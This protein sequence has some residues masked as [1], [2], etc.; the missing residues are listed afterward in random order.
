MFIE[1]TSTKVTFLVYVSILG[2]YKMDSNRQK[3]HINENI[4]KQIKSIHSSNIIKITRGKW[5]VTLQED[6]P[7][8]LLSEVY[9]QTN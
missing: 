9:F 6:I 4:R 7:D 3:T 1:F 5:K 2:Q 8:F